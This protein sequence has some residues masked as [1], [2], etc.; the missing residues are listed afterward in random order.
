MKV[1]LRCR[2]RYHLAD[3]LASFV[4]V[5]RDMRECRNTSVYVCLFV[6][7]V[8]QLF[9]SHRLRSVRLC[10]A[11]R[12]SARCGRQDAQDVQ[13]HQPRLDLLGPA[14]P[15]GACRTRTHATQTQTLTR[16]IHTLTHHTHTLTLTSVRLLSLL[17]SLSPSHAFRPPHTHSPVTLYPF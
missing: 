10:G 1:R 14:A 8:W 16:H 9:L 4:H 3:G 11:H 6:H 15:A 2:G 12:L 13:N 5:V 17:R 7:S